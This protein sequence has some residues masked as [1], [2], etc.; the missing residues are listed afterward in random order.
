MILVKIKTRMKKKKYSYNKFDGSKVEITYG[1]KEELSK[2][3]EIL[4]YYRNDMKEPDKYERVQI[5]GRNNNSEPV[6]LDLALQ[7]YDNTGV[8]LGEG[9][10]SGNNMVK[11][12][13]EFVISVDL[14]DDSENYSSVKLVI[15]ATKKPSYV[16]D[17]EIKPE[18][19]SLTTLK[20]GNIE[21]YIKNNSGQESMYGN[22]GFLFYKEGK[23]V[24]ASSGYFDTH[25]P[26]GGTSKGTFYNHE[27]SNGKFGDEKKTIEYDDVKFIVFSL[28]F[29]DEQNY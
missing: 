29:S 1:A 25:I 2:N 28:Y 27:I 22:G 5:Y 13:S 6:D 11:A 24:Y 26:V 7:Y 16:T 3:I 8:R 14:M 23:L 12:N 15:E 19:I 21:V 20:D 17:V 9:N 4:G 18:D 10:D